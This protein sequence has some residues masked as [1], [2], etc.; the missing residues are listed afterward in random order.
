MQTMEPKLRYNALKQ[1]D[2]QLLDAYSTDSE[3]KQY[4]MKILQDDQH[5]F[6]PYQGAPL[7]RKETLKKY[8]ELK[9]ILNKL[10][11]KITEDEMQEMNYLVNVDGQSAKIVA[12]QYLQKHGILNK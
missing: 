3:L 9:E 8:P 6:P 1:G 4:N 2:I 11:G 5:L 7:L 12:K 10:A